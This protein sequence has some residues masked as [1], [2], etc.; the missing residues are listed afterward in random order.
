MIDGKGPP[1]DVVN[2]PSIAEKVLQVHV[3]ALPGSSLQLKLGIGSTIADLKGIIAIKWRIPRLLQMLFLGKELLPDVY[4]LAHADS[5]PLHVTLVLKP[6]AFGVN[7]G[8]SKRIEVLQEL[9][10]FRGSDSAI[11]VVSSLLEDKYHDVQKIAMQT[12][13]GLIEDVTRL[14]PVLCKYLQDKE[15]ALVPPE[16]Y[17]KLDLI[18]AGY[19][20]KHFKDFLTAPQL[21]EVGFTLQECSE[22]DITADLSKIGCSIQKLGEYGFKYHQLQKAG[23]TVFA[24]RD[25]GACL[26]ELINT[27]FTMKELMDAGYTLQDFKEEGAKEA[28]IEARKQLKRRHFAPAQL[29]EV[30]F[31]LRELFESGYSLQHILKSGLCGRRRRGFT[32]SELKEV[33]ATLKSI[34]KQ[35][36]C[37]GWYYP[38]E[39]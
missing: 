10:S 29:I 33:G 27:S 25:A 26:P 24:L 14:M 28:L 4:R 18:T 9:K 16:G 37:A 7:D 32:A 31:S 35:M 13:C 36:L 38:C 12:L 1:L 30:G 17:H 20:L 34:N 6:L 2:E 39:M 11:N 23:F 15:P 5:K 22:A 19:S 3:T 8:K 21:L